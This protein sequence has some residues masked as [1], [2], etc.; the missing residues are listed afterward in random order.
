MQSE[1]VLVTFKLNIFISHVVLHD[2][3]M[4]QAFRI[5]TVALNIEQLSRTAQF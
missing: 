1:C 5:M 4:V 2:I 3:F